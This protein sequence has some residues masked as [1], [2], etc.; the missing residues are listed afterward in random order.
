MTSPR[1]VTEDELA[2]RL[3]SALRAARL[4]QNID[5]LTLARQ[6]GVS[7]TAL[8]NLESGGGTVRTLIRVIRAL[9]REGWL[10]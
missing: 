8:K 6:A 10:D 2:A 1:H 9:G 7:E 4:A 3:G 5:Q